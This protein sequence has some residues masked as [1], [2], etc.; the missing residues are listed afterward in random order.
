MFAN[1]KA[2]EGRRACEAGQGAEEGFPTRPVLSDSLPASRA[3]SQAQ[4]G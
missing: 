2:L 3:G 4:E 1:F